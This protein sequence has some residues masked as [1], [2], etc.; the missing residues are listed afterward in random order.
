MGL[1][2][3]FLNSGCLLTD[4]RIFFCISV[5]NEI[6]WMKSLRSAAKASKP[7]AGG[8]TAKGKSPETE[9]QEVSEPATEVA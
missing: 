8:D 1:F 3:F 2:G 5:V 9:K 4:Y 7:A 6:L